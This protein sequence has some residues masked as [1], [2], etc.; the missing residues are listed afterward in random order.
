MS[1]NI[2]TILYTHRTNRIHTYIHTYIRMSLKEAD[3]IT[4]YVH[5]YVH[6]YVL[7]SVYNIVSQNFC[8]VIRLYL[9]KFELVKCKFVCAHSYIRTYTHIVYICT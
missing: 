2:T 8:F 4:T 1:E 9:W 3:I 7:H 6:V 5:T